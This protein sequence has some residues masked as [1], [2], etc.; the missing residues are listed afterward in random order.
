MINPLLLIPAYGATYATK[1]ELQAAWEAGKDFCDW[2]GGGRYCSIRDLAALSYMTSTI[3]IVDMRSRVE[4]K[5]EPL[6]QW[7]H[8]AKKRGTR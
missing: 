5:V 8:V 6:D 1:E 4:I 7:A 3:T 2:R